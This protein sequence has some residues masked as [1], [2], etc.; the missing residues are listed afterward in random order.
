MKQIPN[1]IFF[2]EIERSLKAGRKVTIP[3]RGVSMLP[4]LRE[5]RD[6]V[7]LS[8]AEP[9]TLKKGDVVLFRYHGRHI[10]HRI[11]SKNGTAYHM[12]GD[13]LLGDGE[14]C[15]E[16]DIIAK[17]E[18]VVRRGDGHDA[19]RQ[20]S[21]VSLEWRVSSALWLTFRPILLRIRHFLS[22]LKL[23]ASKTME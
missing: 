11:K 12:Q 3:M 14:R 19:E 20:I 15:M 22:R 5:E 18:H 16:A 10:L 4:L 1:A 13:G 8:A 17:V 6:A 7:C 21:T 9:S 23:Y 2:A